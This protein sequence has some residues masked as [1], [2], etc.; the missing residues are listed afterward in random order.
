MNKSF[1]WQPLL[2]CLCG[3]MV[4]GC[5]TTKRLASDQ[6]LYTG[7][8]KID[9]QAADSAQKL[10]SDVVS[11]VEQ[12]LSVKPNNPL[13]S[14]YIRTPFPIGL[15][16]YN[17]FY[18]DKER[19]LKHW[20]YNRLAKKPVLISDVKPDIRTKMVRDILDNNGYFGSST[21]YEQL[22][23]KNPKKAR[24]RYQIRVAPPWHYDSIAY[25]E[26]VSPL[27]RT[28][29][30]LK[31]SSLL[32][33]GARYDID[34]LT[35][36]RIRLTDLLRNESYYYFRPEYLEYL[37]DTTQHPYKVNLRMVLAQGIPPA[38]QRPY[39]VR[40]VRISLFNP[41]GGE[42]D[43]LEYRGVKIRYQKP[44]KIRPRLLT[45]SLQISPG[46]P[47]RVDSINETLNNLTRLDIFRYVN[48]N[49]PSLDSLQPGDSLDMLISA[50]FDAPME[51]QFEADF[52]TKS[53]SFIGPGL[54]FG[55]QHKN[56]FRGGE[57]LGIHLTGNYEW[58]T[59]NK[60]AEVNATRVNSYEF[61]LTAS[62]SV[63]RLLAPRFLA[64][65]DP[66]SPHTTARL[67]ANLL[68]RPKFFTMLSLGASMGYDFQSSP[69]SFHNLT[70][71]KLVYNRL[72]STTS[73]F[74][75]TMSANPWIALS[76]Q[77]QF[78][79]SISY[80]YTYDRAT[81]RD[82]RNR[83]VWQSSFTSA[84]NLFYLLYEM[85]GAKGTKQIFGNRFS[86]FVKATTE[87][88]YYL[89][90]G[91]HNTLAS[92]LMVGVGHAY[93]N[94]A[95][96]PY[97]EQFYI[98]GANSIRAFTIRSLGPGSYRSPVEDQTGY[99]D[100]TGNFKLE[101]NVEFRFRIMGPLNGAVFLDAGNIWLLQNEPD[102]PG[103]QLTARG[104]WRDIALGTGF[105]LRYDLDFL[106]LRAD[107]GIGL[108]TPY[109]NPDKPGY[110]NIPSFKDGLGFHL[111]IGYPF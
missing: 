104:F 5:S 9:I 42:T 36:E 89:R 70:L 12:N 11:E 101:A 23:Q 58:Q 34:T 98:G 41:L 100:Q 2:V 106:V 30:S 27:T 37:A 75:S 83:L 96:L 111:A 99:F 14:P 105:G 38:A 88:K 56:L 52:S 19:G 33:V 95:V 8:K 25:P 91:E 49:V 67:S 74:D 82:G 94:S 6:V 72:I 66:Y 59:G 21:T 86:Q 57:V 109:P 26:P 47:A 60:S 28:L 103:G 10:P 77:D 7:V 97:S 81:G 46:E 3:L 1:G 87:L 107:L 20:L 54:T 31:Q 80:T 22:L 50:A 4:A 110:Y 32:R 51:A 73:A 40:D 93:G 15:W 79:P 90:V 39:R 68:K 17:A 63:P 48:L 84:G 76:F 55:V 43:S 62:L 65:L 85:C 44:L 24:L 18:T 16:A 102:R 13:Y 64:R 53:N 71:F 69:R 35:Q 108:H 45:R 61:G 29:D 92:R 78:I